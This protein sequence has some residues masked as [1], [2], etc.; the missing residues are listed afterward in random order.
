MGAAGL[1][2]EEL[3]Q[4]LN[5]YRE[6]VSTEDWAARKQE[7][8]QQLQERLDQLETFSQTLSHD[9]LCFRDAAHREQEIERFE[10]AF[11]PAERH[12]TFE[13][14]TELFQHVSALDKDFLGCERFDEEDE[15]TQQ[16]L[17]TIGNQVLQALMAQRRMV[18]MPVESG[19][20]QT[21]TGVKFRFKVAVAPLGQ[22]MVLEHE[23]P[24]D[25]SDIKI[26]QLNRKFLVLHHEVQER[27]RGLADCATEGDLA[28][29]LSEFE[30]Q[31][32][33]A[34][35]GDVCVICQEEM[36]A[37]EHALRINS[38]GHCFHAECVKGWL[39]GCKHECPICKAPVQAVTT[40]EGAEELIP[41][42]TAVLIQGLQS[43][44]DLNGTSGEIVGYMEQS[45]RYRVRT[46][47]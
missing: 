19:F 21:S 33:D 44:A 27:I 35:L 37:G 6:L 9:K 28:S 2:T 15:E 26:A 17:A 20:E 4:R 32:N 47:N 30:L 29:Q 39:L 8:H 14:S 5:F 23:V 1:A 34:A 25:R 18:F 12:R 7:V 40:E 31:S 46:E 43:R 22:Q 13:E 45:A 38:C 24:L 42:G 36:Q 10:Q 16:L 11:D 41:E 3:Q